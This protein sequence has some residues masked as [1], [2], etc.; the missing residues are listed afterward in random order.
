MR[1]LKDYRNARGP[2]YTNGGAKRR[3]WLVATDVVLHQNVVF[4]VD[5]RNLFCKDGL[6]FDNAGASRRVKG[7]SPTPSKAGFGDNFI[8]LR[9]GLDGPQYAGWT[10]GRRIRLQ[11]GAD[12]LAWP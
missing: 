5:V 11:A 6:P 4:G 3:D 9:G 12:A 2:A 10:P 7:M 8:P 1:F